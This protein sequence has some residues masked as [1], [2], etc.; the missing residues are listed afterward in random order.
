MYFTPMDNEAVAIDGSKV[1]AELHDLER[2]NM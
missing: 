2:V 1:L